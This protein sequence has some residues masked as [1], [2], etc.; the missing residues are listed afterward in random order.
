MKIAIV[1]AGFTGL[2]AAYKLVKDKHEIVVFEKE[3]LPGGLA[4]GF[5]KKGWQ[6][7]LEKYYHHF[8][9][10]DK[11]ILNL[12]KEVKQKTII[13]RTKTSVYFSRS[14]HQLDSPLNLLRF[15][16]LNLF[17]RFRMGLVLA[18]L[19]Y[20]PFWQQLENL[21]A[22]DFLTKTMG[23]KAYETVWKPQ[24]KNKFGKYV[25]QISLAWFWARVK[26]RTAK[27]AYPEGG[28]L[29]FAK[30]IVKEI[31]NK[32][33]K[34][35]FNAEV[36]SI[37]SVNEKILIKWTTSN[38]KLQ[39]ENFDK[40]I[41]TLSSDSFLKIAQE[42]PKEYKN[43]LNRLESLGVI[44]LVLR[45]KKPFLTDN[46]YW[47]SICDLNSPLMAIVEHTNYMDKNFYNHEHLVYLGNY[48][49]INHSY[50]QM[51]AKEIF[52][53]FTP[54]LKKINPSFEK[55]IIDLDLFK[56]SF[57]QPII[58]VNYSKIMPPFETPIR[59]V[60]LANMQQVYPWDRGTNYAVELGK[61]VVE[62]INKN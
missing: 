7:P 3:N 36:T 27:L 20:N 32:G 54:F 28:F 56:D 26:K 57:A 41:V 46:T 2:S 48:F 1:G 62:V 4:G 53:I 25:N 50:F 47:L 52:K 39:S 58:P 55:L 38:G 33:G 42:L 24:L 22:E 44:N 11:H 51:E 40:L 59:N 18:V 43:K 16:K 21:K 49:P 19:K 34:I 61:K 15:N 29:E 60:Y 37:K 13:K 10:N 23:K 17:E 35:L 14:I 30:K 45:L 9:T 12:A 6:W 5:K 8:F 31:E